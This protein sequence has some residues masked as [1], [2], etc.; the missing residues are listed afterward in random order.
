MILKIQN[1]FTTN[2]MDISLTFS[3]NRTRI[4]ATGSGFEKS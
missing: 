3:I 4:V 1:Y 2:R